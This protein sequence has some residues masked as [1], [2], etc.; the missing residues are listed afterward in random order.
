MHSV[1]QSIIDEL[2]QSLLHAWRG[3]DQSIIDGV[4]LSGV[5]GRLQACTC[6]LADVGLCANNVSISISTYDK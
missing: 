6:T 5:R 3:M 2:K 1:Y 4:V